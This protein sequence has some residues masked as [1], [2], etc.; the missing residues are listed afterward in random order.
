MKILAL[1]TTSE[2]GSLALAEDGTVC[3]EV[4]LHS[5]DGFAHVLFEQL[6]KLLRRH[7]WTLAELD[8]LATTAGPG[9]F[10][11]VRVGLTAVKGIAEAL[12]KPLVVLSNLHVLASFGSA[13]LRAA[14]LDARR[15]EIFGAVYD[16]AGRLVLEE[17]VMKF[18]DW[19]ERLPEGVEFVTQAAAVFEP[20]LR[21]TRFEHRVVTEAPRAL[22]GAVARIACQAMTA[23]KTQDALLA[24]ANYVRRSDAE[25]LWKDA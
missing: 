19:L 5:P 20:M 4:V 6:E 15:G 18:P 11:G 8:C 2:F 25:L 10:T 23:G 13:P 9:S 24:D 22:A 17:V 21:G 14:L 7:G 12:G 1:D 3:E 16:A